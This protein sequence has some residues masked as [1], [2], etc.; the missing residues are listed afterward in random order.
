MSVRVQVSRDACL[1]FV[2]F[3]ILLCT[4][5]NRTRSVVFTYNHLI[6]I[7]A[8]SYKG[9]GVGEGATLTDSVRV[10]QSLCMV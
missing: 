7:A 10:K 1:L 8:V 3:L 9:V 2:Y 5:P 4:C 6:S